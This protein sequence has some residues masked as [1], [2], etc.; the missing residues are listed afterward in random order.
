ML[1]SVVTCPRRDAGYLPAT[2]RGLDDAGSGVWA[3]RTVF[4]DG[5][6]PNVPEG[7]DLQSFPGPSGVRQ[8]MWR[9]FRAA[10]NLGGRLLYC[11]DDI[12]VCRNFCEYAAAVE[13]PEDMAFVSFF[14]R[15]PASANVR[16]LHRRSAGRH[17]WN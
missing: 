12:A 3:N 7:W 9:V 14:R 16:G 4:A 13:I 17:L 2:L 5:Y 1:L 11:E 10:H 8:A 15:V 6:T